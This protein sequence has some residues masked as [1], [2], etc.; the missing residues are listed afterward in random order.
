MVH[1]AGTPTML[2]KSMKV[3][4]RDSPAIVT[5]LVKLCVSVTEKDR[6]NEEIYDLVNSRVMK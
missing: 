1:T 2:T 6:V 3:V 4:S 5:L